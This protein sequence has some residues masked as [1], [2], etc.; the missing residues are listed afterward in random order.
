MP[1]GITDTK[2]SMCAWSFIV[3]YYYIYNITLPKKEKTDK[4]TEH[5][6]TLKTVC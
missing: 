2:T 5:V 3:F 4:I 1:Q 6:W